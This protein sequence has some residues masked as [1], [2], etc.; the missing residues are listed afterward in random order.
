GLIAIVEAGDDVASGQRALDLARRE[1]RVHAVTG[2]HPH[3]ASSL[4][5][6]R[7]ALAALLDTGEYVG[8]GEIGLDFYRDLSPRDQQYEA[9]RWQLGLAHEHDL[10]VVIHCREADAEGFGVL[11]EW[12]DR[13]GRYLGPDREVGMLHCFAGDA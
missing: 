8:V 11:A 9:F 1:P 13:V 10:P 5:E 3:G 7:E 6:E 12:A 4:A 2:L